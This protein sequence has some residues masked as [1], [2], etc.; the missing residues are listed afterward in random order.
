[1][2]PRAVRSLLLAIEFLT[3]VRLRRTAD[4][5][6]R[7]VGESLTW[8]PVVGLLIGLSLAGADWLLHR[9]FPIEYRE[10]LG[11]PL[12]MLLGVVLTGALHL[13]G[14]AD[15][16]DGL[17]GGRTRQQRLEIMKDSRIGTFGVVAVFFALLLTYTSLAALFPEE[18]RVALLCV[19]IISRYTMVVAVTL[20]PSA[21]PAGLGK[22]FHDSAS[23]IAAVG[24]SALAAG[25]LY[26]VGVWLDG[27]A[28][29]IFL[30]SVLPP[31]ILVT[32]VLGLF[33]ARRL[34]GLTGDVHGAIG[35]LVEVLL[36]FL[37]AACTT[38]SGEILFL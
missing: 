23:P 35:M 20:F 1:V 28:T 10:S 3:I 4:L 29:G 31:S 25:I 5:D 13:D 24:S 27:T 37:F 14:L 12:I 22:M 18:R 34:G 38:T 33:A 21:R 15:T 8:F 17:F 16:A 9:V 19:P 7:T 32:A 2:L 30:V 11:I 36:F 26:L 6:P